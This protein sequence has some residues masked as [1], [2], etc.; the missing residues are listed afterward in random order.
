[1]LF[2][3]INAHI[4]INNAG[5]ELAVLPFELK[6][7]NNFKSRFFNSYNEAVDEYF[8]KIDSENIKKPIDDNIKEKIK[9]QEKILKNQK[10]YLEELKIKKKKIFAY[11]ALR[12]YP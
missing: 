6:M 9:A 2:G 5:E 10:E 7:F 11:H 3:N 12:S 4:I 8:S 1:M